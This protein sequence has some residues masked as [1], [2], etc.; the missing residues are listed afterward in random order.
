[1][2]ERI[3]ALP[4]GI[5]DDESIVAVT[6]EDTPLVRRIAEDLTLPQHEVA[7]LVGR[8]M[9]LMEA[10][11]LAG[12]DDP[13][14]AQIWLQSNRG[15]QRAIEFYK[16]LAEEEIGGAVRR[17]LAILLDNEDL[18]VKDKTGVIRVAAN[19]S[20]QPHARW[21]DRARLGVEK[22]RLEL[23]R[24]MSGQ[25]V[26]HGLQHVPEDALDAEFTVEDVTPKPKI[27]V[28]ESKPETETAQDIG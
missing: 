28:N 9:S 16:S 12:L 22:E 3:A 8:G 13:A 4:A 18:D 6:F 10:G 20:M 7:F 19:V 21:R 25:Q 5:S 14:D 24:A 15:F 17:E 27:T 2:D 23:Q 11:R 26:S 1:M